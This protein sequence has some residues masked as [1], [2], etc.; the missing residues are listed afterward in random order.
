MDPTSDRPTTQQD[1]P[2]PTPAREAPP[3]HDDFPAGTLVAIASDERAAARVVDSAREAG[4]A[5][6]HVLPSSDVLAHDAKRREDQGPLSALVQTLGALVSDQRPIQD[7]YLEHARAGHP[8]VVLAAG[9]EQTAERLWSIMKG[10][11]ARDGTW[12]GSGVIR[13]ML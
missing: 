8:M 2:D 11:G 1:P 12:Y 4:A 9:D 6:A 3:A 10:N 7:R 13:E 5:D